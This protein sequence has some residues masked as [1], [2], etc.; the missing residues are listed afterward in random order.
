MKRQVAKG[1]TMLMLVVG[2]ALASA[3]VANGQSGRQVTAQVPFDFIVAE[4][5]LR[6]GQYDVINVSGAGEVLAIRDADGKSQAMRLTSPVIAN[7]RQ[8]MNAKLVFH[9]YG[10]TYFLSQVWLAGRSTGR[11]FA[12]TKQERAI[13]H[14]LKKIATY[15]G[16]WNP[17][18]EVVAVIASAR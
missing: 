5:T 13:E 10:N 1:L 3:A 7:G 6:S 11:E 16:D 12:K 15:H 17:V 8:D 9:R 2:L 18:Y 14:E 4:R